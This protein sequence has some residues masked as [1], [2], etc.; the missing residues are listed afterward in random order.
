MVKNRTSRVVLSG[1]LPEPCANERKNRNIGQMSVWL[2]KWC[3]AQRFRYL[4]LWDHS[5]GKETCISG[6]VCASTEEEPISWW[7]SALP[8][9]AQESGPDATD[10]TA[11]A[12]PDWSFSPTPTVSKGVY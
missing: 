1:L 5:W 11:A 7:V 8:C 10:L 9:T 12:L 4:D 6:T 3:R 2:R